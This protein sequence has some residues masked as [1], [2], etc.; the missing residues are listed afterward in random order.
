MEAADKQYM[1]CAARQQ[2][3]RS[4]GTDPDKQ[5]PSRLNTDDGPI[6]LLDDRVSAPAYKNAQQVSCVGGN[7]Q[8]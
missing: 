4:A 1:N 7:F 8:L 3:P 6:V 5:V 2:D